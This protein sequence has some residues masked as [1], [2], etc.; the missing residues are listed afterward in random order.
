ME[1]EYWTAPAARQGATP[2]GGRDGPH[3]EVYDFTCPFDLLPFIGLNHFVRR[4]RCW[5]LAANSRCLA[6][7]F[8]ELGNESSPSSL[9]TRS[10]A[11][12]IVAMEIFVKI[13]AVAPMR[14]A[15]KF[16]EPAIHGTLVI[17][18]TK[19]NPH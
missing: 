4:V 3:N 13:E 15:L 5:I 7:L 18:R 11:S 1:E 9:V 2:F 10:D 6:A 14:I 17:R 16:F 8:E 19:E 12:S